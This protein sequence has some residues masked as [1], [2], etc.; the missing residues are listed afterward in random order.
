MWTGQPTCFRN[1]NSST[2]NYRPASILASA[3]ATSWGICGRFGGRS[4]RDSSR[5]QLVFICLAFAK[6]DFPRAFR[7]ALPCS[8]IVCFAK[9]VD[10]DDPDSE[11]AAA[12]AEALVLSLAFPAEQPNCAALGD[13]GKDCW[14]VG[15]CLRLRFLGA[16]VPAGQLPTHRIHPGVS[17]GPHQ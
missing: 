7:R 4:R 5:G 12:A 14:R 15:S 2:G 6:Y 1:A 8:E 13:T 11:S 3:R 9:L 16:V 10:S 17:P